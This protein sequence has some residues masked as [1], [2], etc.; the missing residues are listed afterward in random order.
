VPD[1][2]WA[3]RWAVPPRAL[4]AAPLTVSE[5]SED[6]RFVFYIGGDLADRAP[7]SG[8]CWRLAVRPTRCPVRRPIPAVAPNG[9]RVR[10]GRFYFTLG[11]QQSD[12]WMTEVDG[13]R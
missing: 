3:L 13:S 9:F 11:D 12:I 7:G 6:G 5:W 4:G 8:V 2:G 1:S 10:G